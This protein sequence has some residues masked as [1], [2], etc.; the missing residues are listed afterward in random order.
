MYLRLMA[1]KAS[2]PVSETIIN[3]LSLFKLNE[4]GF[5]TLVNTEA[6]ADSVNEKL[7]DN[8]TALIILAYIKENESDEVG[9]TKD[10][11]AKYMH[12]KGFCSRPTTLRLIDSLLAEEI[13][14]DKRTR[15]NVFHD[16]V[17]SGEINFDDLL[18]ESLDLYV[19]EVEKS[20]KPLE[21]LTKYK[22][23]LEKRVTKVS[24]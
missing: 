7:V 14:L 19:K 21:A 4:R 2:L 24:K 17:I 16:L 12:D 15:K 23:N 6:K 10:N 1:R 11:V 18:K 3:I 22:I 8:I 20:L 5:E 9:I 13:L